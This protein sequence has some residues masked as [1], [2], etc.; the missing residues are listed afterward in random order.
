VLGESVLERETASWFGTRAYGEA[1][2]AYDLASV[3]VAESDNA[4]GAFLSFSSLTRPESR[5]DVKLG[6]TRRAR[7]L[8]LSRLKRWWSAPALSVP[9]ETQFLFLEVDTS[10]HTL[11]VMLLPLLSDDGR[12]RC[13]L[14]DAAAADAS[15]SSGKK[16]KKLVL[17]ARCESG[18]ASAR[19]TAMEAAL[20]VGGV[21]AEDAASAAYHLLD[22]GLVA[23]SKRKQFAFRPLKHKASPLKTPFVQGLG[24]CTWDA[25][26]SAVDAQQID[27][28]LETLSAHGARV[29]RL[30]VDDGW[31]QL[32]REP[33]TATTLHDEGSALMSGQTLTGLSVSDTVAS[34]LYDKV[35]EEDK[36]TGSLAKLGF[37]A[38]HEAFTTWLGK[39]Y[40]T[41]VESGRDDS[42]PVALWRCAAAATP[43]RDALV[44]FYDEHTDFTRRLKWPPEP[45]AVKFGGVEG[46]AAFVKNIVRGK[47]GVDCVAVWHA[48][49]GHWGGVDG[50]PK[51]GDAETVCSRAA[52]HLR[53]V[54]PS[55]AWDPASLKGTTTPTTSDGIARL[56][57]DLYAMLD[58]CGVDGVKA[59]AQSGVAPMGHARG[60]GPRSVAMFVTAM[61]D[62]AKRHFLQKKTTEEE[63]R[64]RCLPVTNCMCHS[65]E[66]LYSY[67]ATSLARASDDFYPR[68]PAS[69]WFHLTA[70]AYNSIFLGGI[71]WPDWDMF[72]SKHPA[73]WTHAA[74]RA[75]SGSPVTVSDAP[76]AHDAD[77]LR[78]LALPS[79]E[80]LV[81][82]APGRVAADC[83]FKDVASDGETALKIVAPSNACGAAVAGLFNVQGSRWCR[84]AR[85]YVTTTTETSS[86][87]A[88]L[89]PGDLLPAFQHELLEEKKDR[90]AAKSA[91]AILTT[92]FTRP[93]LSRSN[94]VGPG[95]PRKTP[96]RSPFVGYA[97][98]RGAVVDFRD[99]ARLDVEL[100]APG[101]FEVVAVAPLRTAA[102]DGTQWAPLGLLDMLNG[103]GAVL[104]VDEFHDGGL[105]TVR[106][107][108][109]FALF[110]DREPHRVDGAHSSYDDHTRLVTVRL[111]QGRLHR[112]RFIW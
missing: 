96:K 102:S 51:S 57:D 24:W 55:I 73:A 30:I 54:E 74:A 2:R 83:L 47:H 11:Y 86:L 45:H 82:I 8:A 91:E 99:T 39:A 28:G 1:T 62:A 37:M 13:S 100:K 88:S 97:F 21:F 50:F 106:G 7:T 33:P 49:A 64:S 18:D 59:D 22:R 112:L 36:V 15:S 90:E 4:G 66:N 53:Y 6:T 95:K 44:H 9:L 72:Q 108:G 69:W 60:G 14:W 23:A 25:C 27:L 35:D 68:D 76:G 48:V 12:F 77:V 10:P 67:A 79:G 20:W 78:A 103:G 42:V 111:A 5:F 16:K 89:Q 43:L 29:R 52:P 101:D 94:F 65:T 58:R 71:A 3:A 32:D 105:V 107:P 110:A 63:H 19:T 80:T 109:R 81:A 61:E 98:S 34:H 87:K 93:N 41:Y 84:D 92:A 17:R 46:F 85:R 40:A 31:M 104:D 26:Y 70:C 75:V 38:L 56:Y